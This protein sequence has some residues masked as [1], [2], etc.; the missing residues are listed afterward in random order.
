MALVLMQKVCRNYRGLLYKDILPIERLLY[1]QIYLFYWLEL[2]AIQH[3]VRILLYSCVY[4]VV[5]D[6]L[7][8]CD[9]PLC[10]CT[11]SSYIQ[12]YLVRNYA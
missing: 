7:R 12:H 5:S 9:T 6:I 8:I 10:A 1:Y 2:N 3:C 11:A 4:S